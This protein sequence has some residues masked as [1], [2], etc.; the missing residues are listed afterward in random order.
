MAGVSTRYIYDEEDILLELDET[1]TIV[2]RYTHGPAVDEPL[3]M[4]R[5][6]DMSGSFEASEVF[7]YHA[8]ALGSVTEITDN[9]GGLARSY[10]YESFGQIVSETG[11]PENPYTYTGRELD[12]ATGLYYYRARYY[13]SRVGR[14]ISSDPL[15][16]S[17]GVNTYL[18]VNGNPLTFVDPTGLYK[19]DPGV[20]IPP[21]PLDA[22][23]TCIERCLETSFDVTSTIRQGNTPHGRGEAADIRYRGPGHSPFTADKFMCCASRC[24]AGFGLDEWRNPIPGVTRGPHLHVQLGPGIDG[25]SRGILPAKDC[26]LNPWCNE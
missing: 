9:L 19:L 16:V 14:F 13:D 5:D 22:L 17:A 23:L 24:G 11:G 20:P 21:P 7:F 4:E 26:E 18:Y 25:K 2:A 1:S 3:A 12:T 15:G 8:D 6:L 10:V